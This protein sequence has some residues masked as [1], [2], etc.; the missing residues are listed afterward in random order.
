[1]DSLLIG[2]DKSID[3]LLIGSDQRNELVS[4]RF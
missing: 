4:S 3:S 1:M 2:S